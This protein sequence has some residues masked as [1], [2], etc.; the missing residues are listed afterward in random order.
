MKTRRLIAKTLQAILVTMGL[1]APLTHADEAAEALEAIG[2][3]TSAFSLCLGTNPLVIGD[4]HPT[5]GD[6]L[7]YLRKKLTLKSD[8]NANGSS[9]L[10]HFVSVL[11]KSSTTKALL[12]ESKPL[13]V[14]SQD[15][16][17]PAGGG[18]FTTNVFFNPGAFAR[19]FLFPFGG[20]CTGITA[21]V[22]DGKTYL[23]L[24]AGTAAAE[25]DAET[26]TDRTRLRVR[27]IDAANG[28]TVRTTSIYAQ[29]G[30]FIAWGLPPLVDI[31]DDGDIELLVW[32]VSVTNDSRV[33]AIL[34]YYDL[35][36][37]IQEGLVAVPLNDSVVIEP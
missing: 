23:I 1:S 25:G 30:N 10:N 26:G 3:A 29:S 18:Q 16:F 22:H 6:E 2:A 12:Y 15:I 28:N 20:E 13:A 17:I 37:G 4:V 5:S 27:V 36:S 35:I 21:A 11:V 8:T 9:V 24:I 32:R 34:R 19:F 7:V 31:D 33:T 14:N